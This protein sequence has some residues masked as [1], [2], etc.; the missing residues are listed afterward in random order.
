MK[1]KK[2][3]N[4]GTGKKK[5][6]SQQKKTVQK[7]HFTN[8]EQVDNAWILKDESSKYFDNLEE[9]ATWT[10][11]SFPFASNQPE[12]RNFIFYLTLKIITDNLLLK[13]GVSLNLIIFLY[14]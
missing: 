4:A 1:V 12:M 3:N 10:K 8:E 7:P 6:G 14:A 11:S 13:L 9:E 2:K 5:R